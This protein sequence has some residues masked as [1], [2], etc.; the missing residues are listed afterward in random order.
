MS[1][2]H[3]EQKIKTLAE[4]NVN[5]ANDKTNPEMTIDDYIFKPWKYNSNGSSGGA[6]IVSQNIISETAIFAINTFRN[7]LD[8]IVQRLSLVSQC[9]MDFYIEPFLINKLDNNNDNIFF[10]RHINDRAGVGLHFDLQESENYNKINNFKYPS[11]L[12]FLQECCNTSGYVPKLMLLLCSLEALSGKVE[13]EKDDKIYSSYNKNEMKKIIGSQLYDELYGERGIRH[14]LNH[15]DMIDFVFEKDYVNEIY[16]NIIKYFNL[17]TRT[18]INLEVRSPQRNFSG[19]FE[20]TNL[21]LQPMFNVS[22]ININKCFDFFSKNINLEGKYKF[23][24]GLSL[25]LY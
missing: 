21:I 5:L 19:N 17:T 20:Y 22:D 8:P 11:A 2:Y 12:R 9:Y 10:Y 16:R 25:E 24:S 3:I 4:L 15:G 6:W 14:K 1:N 18:N 23:I 7:K 13:V